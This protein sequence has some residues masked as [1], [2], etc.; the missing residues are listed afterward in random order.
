VPRGAGLLDRGA[1]S[2]ALV[3]HKRK[4][5]SCRRQFLVS[6]Q[7]IQLHQK[8]KPDHF[9]TRCGHQF[10]RCFGRAA[11]GQQAV[12]DDHLLPRL[13]AVEVSFEGGFTVFQAISDGAGFGERVADPCCISTCRKCK[14]NWS[15]LGSVDFP[16]F[17]RHTRLVLTNLCGNAQ[18]L[19]LSEEFG[20]YP[21]AQAVKGHRNDTPMVGGMSSWP[22][23]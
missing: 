1:A 14:V 6:G 15:F 16:W 5:R 3:M 7:K 21:P 11:G 9:G 2:N 13:E 17:R 23:P 19:R 8:Q 22:T 18:I 10:G 12:H 4:N 20:P